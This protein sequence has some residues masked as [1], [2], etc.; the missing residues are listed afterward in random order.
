[1]ALLRQFD[2]KTD[3]AAETWQQANGVLKNGDS[4]LNIV[5]NR[6]MARDFLELA[7]G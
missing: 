4:G 3:F 2:L 5:R 7:T 1:M 6:A